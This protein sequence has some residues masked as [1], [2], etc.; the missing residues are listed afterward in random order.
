MSSARKIAAYLD[1][2]Q[3]LT[4]QYLSL[5]DAFK[6]EEDYAGLVNVFNMLKHLDELVYEFQVY[7][8]YI[9]TSKKPLTKAEKDEMAEI[10]ELIK[11]AED[12]TSLAY[13][14]ENASRLA[15]V[16]RE[17]FEN[18]KEG[19]RLIQGS[20][21]DSGNLVTLK[22]EP[23]NAIVRTK[24]A[25]PPS[26][27]EVLPLPRG[28]IWSKRATQIVFEA[29]NVD[30]PF[31]KDKVQYISSHIRDEFHRNCSNHFARYLLLH[32][33]DGEGYGFREAF[34]EAYL[35]HPNR[36]SI[37]KQAEL[38]QNELKLNK[39]PSTPPVPEYAVTCGIWLR[40]IFQRTYGSIT[41]PPENYQ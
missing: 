1:R 19:G 31:I 10:E 7:K 39:D 9:E 17:L 37:E 15:I 30:S 16:R 38:I 6:G 2:K 18:A 5:K 21:F 27:N 35:K 8:S 25:V 14:T 23:R 13:L 40:E 26:S 11:I 33:I 20:N 34:D 3:T 4:Q 36:P 22:S 28:M 12:N 41:E 29:S 32:Y 24:I